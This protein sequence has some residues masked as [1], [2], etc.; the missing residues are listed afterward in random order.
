MDGWMNKSITATVLHPRFSRLSIGFY[1]IAP[2]SSRLQPVALLAG[3]R[4]SVN[5][6][7]Q[8]QLTFVFL[9]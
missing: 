1:G 4:Q 9:S 8:Y 5:G 2:A 6:S 7:S 3:Y